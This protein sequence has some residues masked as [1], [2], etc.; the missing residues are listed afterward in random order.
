MIKKE[1]KKDK[2][3]HRENVIVFSTSFIVRQSF[4]IISQDNLLRTLAHALS[5]YLCANPD[6]A[7]TKKGQV[8][9]KNH[10]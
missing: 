10:R 8:G 7:K 1:K 9:S 3:C 4:S 2:N 5:S 6:R